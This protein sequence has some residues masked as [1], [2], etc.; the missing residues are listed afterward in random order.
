MGSVMGAGD[1][2]V[3]TGIE[4]GKG[5]TGGIVLS[6]WKTDMVREGWWCFEWDGK[7]GGWDGRHGG[8]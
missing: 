2:G 6:I 5:R 1:I 8:L 4:D 3:S 7:S